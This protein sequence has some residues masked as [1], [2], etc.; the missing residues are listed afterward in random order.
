MSERLK[1]RVLLLF[2]EQAEITTP[3]RDH[4]DP[5]RVPIQRLIR[6]TGIPREELAGAELVAVVGA[7]GE[8]E[9]FER[10]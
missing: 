4:T 6:E 5:E 8:L 3:Y 1:A 7:D 9:R 2:G 10:A